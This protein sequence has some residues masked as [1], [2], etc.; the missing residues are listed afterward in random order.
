MCQ[1]FDGERS[2][3]LSMDRA[4]RKRGYDAQKAGIP[5]DKNP[6]QDHELP[7]YS[8]KRQWWTGWDLANNGRS[9]W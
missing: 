9:I 1:A 2:F 3:L 5:R 6:E 8:D 4:T 7:E